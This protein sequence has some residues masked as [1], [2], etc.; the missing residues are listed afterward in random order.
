MIQKL[1]RQRNMFLDYLLQEVCLHFPAP[2]RCQIQPY[3]NSQFGFIENNE[4]D[5]EVVDNPSEFEYPTPA[6]ASGKNPVYVG[7]IRKD[8]ALDNAISLLG[9]KFIKDTSFN[10]YSTLFLFN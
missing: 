4:G 1:V 3:K 9:G 7:R 2:H 8:I 10:L 5:L 6:L